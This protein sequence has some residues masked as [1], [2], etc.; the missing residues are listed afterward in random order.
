VRLKATNWLLG[1][2]EMVKFEETNLYDV[3]F[4]IGMLSALVLLLQGL[5]SIAEN[6]SVKFS[7]LGTIVIVLIIIWLLSKKKSKKK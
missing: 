4:V 5:K 3:L 2:I 1:G 7:A 6:L